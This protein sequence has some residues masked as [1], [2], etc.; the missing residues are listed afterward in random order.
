[1][2]PLA[3][4]SAEAKGIDAALQQWRQGDL[5]LDERWFIH[6]GDPAEPLTEAAAEAGDEGLQA[7]TSE[8]AGLAVVTQTCDV[9]RSCAMRPYVEVS[10]LVQVRAD[11]LPAIQRGRRPALATLPALLASCLVVDLDR[12]MT[13]E[14][15]VVAKWTR[16]PGYA[17]DV[18]GRAFSRALARKRMRFAFPDDFNEL[19]HKLQARLVDK[20]EKNTVEGRGLRALREIRVQ[21]SPS[22]DAPA[23]SLM[24]WFIRRDEQLDFE[25]KGWA[26]LL[27]D[28]LKLVQRVGRFVDIDGQVATLDELSAAEYV[29]SD[30]LDLDHLSS[31][32]NP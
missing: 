9:V 11:D 5:A 19:A 7:L 15:A 20:H 31:R 1:V 27:K 32:A 23:I 8:V 3:P 4:E 28:W 16:T 10:P 2:P 12:V 13:V 30:A 24:F 17:A 6:A 22:W 29:A 18:D 21:A 26:G 25:G 14:K